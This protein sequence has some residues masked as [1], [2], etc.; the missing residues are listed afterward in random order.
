MENIKGVDLPKINNEM[1]SIQ[2]ITLYN[3]SNKKTRNK[4]LLLPKSYE[5]SILKNQITTRKTNTYLNNPRPTYFKDN[6]KHI[7]LLI[8]HKIPLQQTIKKYL[9]YFLKKD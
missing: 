1:L 3:N 9:N 5:K 4:E 7:D 2:K 8:K 6:K